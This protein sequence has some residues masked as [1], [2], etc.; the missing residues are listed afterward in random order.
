MQRIRKLFHIQSLSRSN[1]IPYQAFGFS[2]IIQQLKQEL[3]ELLNDKKKSLQLQGLFNPFIRE[4][5]FPPTH[6]NLNYLIEPSAIATGLEYN[7]LYDKH[8]DGYV[9]NRADP[10][11]FD[12]VANTPFD[13]NKKPTYQQKTESVWEAVKDFF[14]EEE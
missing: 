6:I 7:K 14:R 10:L 5:F 1:L 12:G 8:I 3:W 13:P 4:Y 9:E 2:G 11:I